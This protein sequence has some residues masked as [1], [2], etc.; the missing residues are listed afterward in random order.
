MRVALTLTAALLAVA[1]AGAGA[2]A[3]RHLPFGD[4]A[5]PERVTCGYGGFPLDALRGPKGVE[6]RRGRP[7]DA[8]RR[9]IRQEQLFGPDLPI[10]GFR[11]LRRA[12]REV[13]F[14]AGHPPRM[15]A[16]VVELSRRLQW[17]AVAYGECRRLEPVDERGRAAVWRLD[18]GSPKPSPESTEIP[19]LVTE[20]DC[21]SGEPATG[22]IAEPRV[23]VG[24]RRVVVSIFVRPGDGAETCPS[25]PPTPYVLR[26][27]EPLG[28]RAL[29][30]GGRIPFRERLAR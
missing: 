2:A 6:R 7:Y 10:R 26:L 12:P 3:A 24:A 19:V 25:N 17:K 18:R 1:A 30:D 16:V 4:P 28:N 5:L 20:Q 11:V 14:A 8:L 29:L 23:H 22:R 13:V 15:G 27:P 9:W 21:A